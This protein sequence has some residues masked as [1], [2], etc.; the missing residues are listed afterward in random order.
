MSDNQKNNQISPEAGAL[1][2]QAVPQKSEQKKQKEAEALR[3]N[4]LRRKQA[5]K[6][7]ANTA[8]QG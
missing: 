3:M 1:R 2:R 4:L 5:K 7:G 8:A 6:P